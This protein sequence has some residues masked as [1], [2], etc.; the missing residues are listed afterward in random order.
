MH[1][2][3][4]V[5]SPWLIDILSQGK[6]LIHGMA[7]H[8]GDLDILIPFNGILDLTGSPRLVAATI[9]IDGVIKLHQSIS[10]L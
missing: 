5:H 6:G 10:C 2:N 9:V 3:L 4:R 7:L 1:L 8:N